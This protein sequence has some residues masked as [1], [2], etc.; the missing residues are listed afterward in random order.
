MLIVICKALRMQRITKPRSRARFLPFGISRQMFTPHS[1]QN[2]PGGCI[3]PLA[4][5]CSYAS[6]RASGPSQVISPMLIHC[7]LSVTRSSA[8]P[9]EQRPTAG[10]TCITNCGHRRCPSR[11]WHGLRILKTK[12][13]SQRICCDILAPRLPHNASGH[14]PRTRPG[15]VFGVTCDMTNAAVAVASPRA[16]KHGIR[17]TVPIPGGRSSA[18][19]A[20]SQARAMLFCAAGTTPST[21]PMPTV[22]ADRL[23]AS[24]LPP[25]AAAAAAS[26]RMWR[27]LGAGLDELRLAAAKSSTSSS[28]GVQLAGTTSAAS[29][30][31]PAT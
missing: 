21:P 12:A 20:I 17:L 14:V 22:A 7:R 27:E 1:H 23:P 30:R 18:C 3:C 11:T 6:C 24:S 13:Y 19:S 8:E 26:A 29:R 5:G 28:S 31:R 15:P 10:E 25:V 16:R 2:P 9:Q 4:I